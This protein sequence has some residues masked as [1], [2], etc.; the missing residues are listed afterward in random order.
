MA[1]KRYDGKQKQIENAALEVYM[2]LGLENLTLES[3]AEKLGYTKQAIYYYFRN[4]EKLISSFC[5]NILKNARDEFVE[6]YSQDL[7]P[8]EKMEA[9]I[10]Y[11]VNGTCLK[12]GFFA[13]QHDFKRI[14][15]LM[16]NLKEIIK[17]KSQISK[18]FEDVITEGIEKGLF[19]EED[20]EALAGTVFMLLGG[21]ISMTEIPGLKDLPTNRKV[22]LITDIIIKGI[23]A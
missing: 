10:F 17:M 22:E 1:A 4:K 18:G 6:I 14:I 7:N 15:P 11:Y 12:K 8:V 19:R 23:Q 3:V 16:D 13:L 20:T 2:E 21:A 9:I 5:F